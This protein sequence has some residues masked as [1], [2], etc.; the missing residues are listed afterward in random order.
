MQFPYKAGLLSCLLSAALIGGCGSTAA[1]TSPEHD[2]APEAGDP[3]LAEDSD[4]T[5]PVFFKASTIDGTDFSSSVFAD[6]R[7]TMVNV[8]ATYCNP[9][10]NEMPD[11]GE[12][13]GA[14]DAADFQLIGIISDIPEGADE[15][16]LQTAL[17]LIEETG[18]DYPHLLLNES[19]YNAL[20]SDVTAVP[21]T[22]FIDQ[23]GQVLDTVIGARDKSAWEETID[24]FLEE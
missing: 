7:I 19:V 23:D 1:K 15:Q 21:T 5:L 4:L 14:Y 22:F 2:P 11:L 17:D 8:W 6:S 3:A 10:L 12:L 18:A 16:K 24:A 13:A 9:C 20:L